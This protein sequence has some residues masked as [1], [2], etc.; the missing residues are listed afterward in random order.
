MAERRALVVARTELTM[1][2]RNETRKRKRMLEKSSKLSTQ[3][4][5]SVLELRQERNAVA[6][7]KAKAKAAV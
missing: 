5:V 1:Q 4:L 3:D 2:L 7:A 6:K